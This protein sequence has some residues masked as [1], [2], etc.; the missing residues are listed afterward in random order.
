MR[1]IPSTEHEASATTDV[2]LGVEC[3]MTRTY[4]LNRIPVTSAQAWDFLKHRS[5]V[6]LVPSFEVESMIEHDRVRFAP[7]GDSAQSRRQSPGEICWTRLDAHN[8]I[9]KWQRKDL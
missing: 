7:Q 2:L 6:L 3:I 4:S 1:G 5:L 9:E 8:N